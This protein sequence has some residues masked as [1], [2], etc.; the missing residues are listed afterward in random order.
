MILVL[1][2]TSESEIFDKMFKQTLSL[3]RLGQEYFPDYVK[4]I[5]GGGKLQHNAQ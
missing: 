1:C 4:D 2:E 3:L 5:S